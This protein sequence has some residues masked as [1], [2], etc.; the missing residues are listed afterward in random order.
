MNIKHIQKVSASSL[1]IS[2]PN[3]SWFGNPGNPKSNPVWTEPDWL[4]S[5][6]HFPF[7]EYSDPKRSGFGVL[8]VCNDDLLQPSRGFGT[9]PHRD[10]EIVTYIVNGALTHQ[11]S[12]G[13]KETLGRGSI[14]FMSAGT[15][16]RHSEANASNDSPLR[17]IQIWIVPRDRGGEPNYGSLSRSA[18]SSTL[19]HLVS[20]TKSSSQTSVRINQD[21]NIYAGEIKEAMELSIGQNRQVYLLCIEGN[22]AI[23][24]IQLDK[25]EAATISGPCQITLSPLEKS[26]LLYIEMSQ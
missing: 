9:H 12:M 23:G 14:Q 18:P 8:R 2:R 20:D 11:D 3:P 21:A 17:F 5:R 10:M 26:H 1:F 15:G 22:I 6:F 24:E 19:E 16:V 4:V 7:A 13:T 25:H